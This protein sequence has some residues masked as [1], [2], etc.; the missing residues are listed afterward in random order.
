M[1]IWVIWY[2]LF[3]LRDLFCSSS[4]SEELLALLWNMYP[5]IWLTFWSR[6]CEKWSG[7]PL[8]TLWSAFRL[9][10]VSPPDRLSLFC[11]FE[12]P[13]LF[14]RKSDGLVPRRSFAGRVFWAVLLALFINPTLSLTGG[15]LGY[16][17]RTT[18]R[19]GVCWALVPSS[20]LFSIAS[21]LIFPDLVSRMSYIVL[22][23]QGADGNLFF[24]YISVTGHLVACWGHLCLP[25]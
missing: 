6:S 12:G 11:G 23:V 9:L 15:F 22:F 4:K 5:P 10:P 1:I 3:H 25:A 17:F 24:D 19:G 13:G 7:R 16:S 18:I 20:C 21:S 8:T 2:Y 14:W